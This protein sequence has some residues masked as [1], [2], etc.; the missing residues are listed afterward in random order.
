MKHGITTILLYFLLNP[1][2]SQVGKRQLEIYSITEY[3]GGYVIKGIDRGK[4][5]TL[6]IVT[7]KDT[8]PAAKDYEKILVGKTYNFEYRLSIMAAAPPC[9]LVI[10]MGTTVL[11]T[12]KDPVNHIP[13]FAENAIGLWIKSFQN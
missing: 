11:W 12:C 9:S 8:V 5:D 3:M 6:N 4:G 7:L 2:F 13:V 1:A 10:R